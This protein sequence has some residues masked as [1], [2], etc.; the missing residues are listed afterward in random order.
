MNETYFC[1]PSEHNTVRNGEIMSQQ[2]T[3]NAKIRHFH[4]MECV[5]RHDSTKHSKCFFTGL[6][7]TSITIKNK[8]PLF[9][10]V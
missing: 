2:A 3:V 8:G 7:I 5:L 4:V 1:L 10:V 6:N 9:S